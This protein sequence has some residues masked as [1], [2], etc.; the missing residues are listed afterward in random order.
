[1]L[2]KYVTG[3]REGGSQ[4]LVMLFSI[5][6]NHLQHFKKLLTEFEEIKSLQI[7][8]ENCDF[9]CMANFA[10][11]KPSFLQDLFFFFK[12]NIDSVTLLGK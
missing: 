3:L 8:P 4:E 5:F 7:S 2:S 12:Q 11:W 9:L 10:H 1:M 6:K